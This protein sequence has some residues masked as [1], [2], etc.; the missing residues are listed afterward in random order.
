MFSKKCI[1]FILTG[2][3]ILC[4]GFRYY[5][6]TG[7]NSDD[8]TVK[9]I[10]ATNTADT[11]L[12][13][14]EKEE[15]ESTSDLEEV[16]LVFSYNTPVPFR[17]Y[18]PTAYRTGR[19]L[20]VLYLLHGQ[21][22][23]EMLWDRLG[24]IGILNDLIS[25]GT[26]QPM[27]VV[28]PRESYYLQ[29]MSE[30]EYPSLIVDTLMPMIAHYFPTLEKRESRAIGGVSRGA[31]WAQKIAFEHYDMF[32]VLGQ[33]SLPNPFF[34]DYEMYSKYKNNL[35]LPLMKI[36]IDTGASDPYLDGAGNFSKQLW[37]LAYP[38]TFILS[39]GDHN[40]E[41]WGAH[42]KEYLIWYADSLSSEQ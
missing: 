28:M 33:H 25:D 6:D 36:Y 1:L 5:D 24:I 26:I 39:P 19:K 38:H 13:S 34:S 29:D 32:G 37:G 20:P 17:I 2:I 30:S 10:P 27:I 12:D 35:E 31:L 15:A 14:V 18:L 23:D 42:I 3:V 41:Y 9:S 8:G 4:S 22:Q 7:M 16:S 40:E 11:I 21:S